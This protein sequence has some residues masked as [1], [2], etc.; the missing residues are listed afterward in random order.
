MNVI[1]VQTRIKNIE[2]VL[3]VSFTAYNS[4]KKT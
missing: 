3:N 2:K 1:F 4:G